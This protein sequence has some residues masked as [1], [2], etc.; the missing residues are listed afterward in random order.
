M[1][2]TGYRSTQ[3]SIHLK[4][5]NTLFCILKTGNC[6][7]P[8]EILHLSKSYGGKAIT[9]EIDAAASCLVWG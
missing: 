1:A 6:L 4:I 9:A 5:G 7:L 8:P 2:V 3:L